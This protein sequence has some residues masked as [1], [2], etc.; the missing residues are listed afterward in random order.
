MLG[1][2]LANS[3]GPPDYKPHWLPLESWHFG[4][5][6]FM[7]LDAAPA[8]DPD[9]WTALAASSPAWPS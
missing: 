9:A 8:D 7:G 4:A 5:Q 3:S 6:Y 1:T 2:A